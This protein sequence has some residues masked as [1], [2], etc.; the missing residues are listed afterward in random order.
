M[1]DLNRQQDTANF[2]IIWLVI[3]Q[4][5]VAISSGLAFGGWHHEY[6][7]GALSD[8][9]RDPFCDFWAQQEEP[10]D[11]EP[12]DHEDQEEADH[13]DQNDHES[14]PQDRVENYPTGKVNASN[15]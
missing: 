14:A 1:F 12:E 11:E 6:S 9:Y 2:I 15:A 7:G 10:E 8:L 13:N 4:H 5:T 3:A